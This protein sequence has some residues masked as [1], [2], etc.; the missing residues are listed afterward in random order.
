MNNLS[1][2]I[3][4]TYPL[5]TLL[6]ICVLFTTLSS[7]LYSVVTLG[8]QSNAYRFTEGES[9]EVVVE[10]IGQIDQSITFRVFSDGLI[11]NTTTIVAGSMSTIFTFV[12]PGF[13]DDAIA[14]Q[15][16]E[17][18]DVMLSLV[19][20]NPQ[21]DITVPVTTVTITDNDGE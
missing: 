18:F 12:I 5:F 9:V 7:S 16:D 20:P 11:D 15:P 19:E 21:V 14:L 3:L 10:Y 2:Y 4:Y 1:L 6:F 17:I 13:E 8:F